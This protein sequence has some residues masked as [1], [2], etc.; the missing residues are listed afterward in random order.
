MCENLPYVVGYYL[1]RC[2]GK[3]VSCY[4]H[5]PEKKVKIAGLTGEREAGL[6]ARCLIPRDCVADVADVAGVGASFLILANS[7]RGSKNIIR[8]SQSD[9]PIDVIGRRSRHPAQGVRAISSIAF[10]EF[11]MELEEETGLDIDIDD[12]DASIRT[13]DQLYDRLNKH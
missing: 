8:P 6:M 3:A 13:T 7:A 10:A 1:C 12:L 9:K 5:T 11:I 2:V 4:E